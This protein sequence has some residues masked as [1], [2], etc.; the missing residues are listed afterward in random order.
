[1]YA[2]NPGGLNGVTNVHVTCVIDPLGNKMFYYNG[3][4]VTSDPGLNNG[5]GGTVPALSGVND[6]FGLLGRSL[7]D[8]DPTLAGALNEFRIYSGVLPASTIA[9]NDAAGPD[10]IVTNPGAITALHFS[11]PVNPLVVNQSLPT[12]PHRRL[13]ERDGLGLD[14]LRRRHL[15][16]AEH[17]C[18]YN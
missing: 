17:E 12:K 15:Q 18:A 3:T 7:F 1:M 16:L 6:M 5:A 14:R 4:K 8:V 11:A 9:L 13:C 10:N 2:N